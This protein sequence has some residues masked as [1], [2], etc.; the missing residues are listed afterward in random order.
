MAMTCGE[1]TNNQTPEVIN[2]LSIIMK[3]TKLK[4]VK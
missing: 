3:I 4:T 1:R 2:E